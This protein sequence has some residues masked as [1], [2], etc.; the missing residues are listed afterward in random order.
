MAPLSPDLSFNTAVS[1]VTNTNWQSYGGETTMSHLSQMMGLTVHNFVSAATGIALAIALTRAFARSQTRD[2]GNFWV[3]LTRSTLYVL[4]P[5]SIVVA[6]ALILLGMPQTLLPWVKVTTL[7][8]V[9]Q[10]LSMGP[11]AS[12]VAIKH[13][14]TNGGGF[15][16]ANSAHPF[17]NPNAWTNIIE[18]WAI[19][20][21]RLCPHVHLWADGRRQAPGLRALRHHGDLAGC[22][23]RR[24]LTWPKPPT[25]RS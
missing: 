4:L 25:I 17:E 10:T 21:H 3:D 24:P 5:L 1:F 2:L 14:G 23:R 22:R 15:F 11:V 18:T 19:I 9:E 20:V 13:L 8:G 16:N 12:Q 7:E 6:L